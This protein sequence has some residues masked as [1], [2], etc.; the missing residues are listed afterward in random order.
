M[1]YVSVA[2][3]L[4]IVLAPHHCRHCSHKRDPA[5]CV[6]KDELSAHRWGRGLSHASVMSATNQS[7]SQTCLYVCI[8]CVCALA[9]TL[10]MSF[11]IHVGAKGRY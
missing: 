9:H 3:S 7:T 5:P 10:H 11:C 1:S 6:V 8:V 2:S 4:Y